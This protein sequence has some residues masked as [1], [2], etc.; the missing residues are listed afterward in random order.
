[1][2]MKENK[3]DCRQMINP[4]HHADHF[5]EKYNNNDFPISNNISSQ[6]IHLPSGLALTNDNI[7]YICMT[8]NKFYKK[9]NN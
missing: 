6:S 9:L 8:L 5:V 3:I 7:D 1:M 4:V 2:F